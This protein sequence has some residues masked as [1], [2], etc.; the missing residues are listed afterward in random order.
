MRFT[1]IIYGTI[2]LPDWLIPFLK[3]PEFV[4]LRGIRLSNVDSFEFKDF[5]GPTRWEHCIGVAYLAMRCAKVKKLSES[6]R[7]HLILAALLHD[8]ATPPFAHTVEYVL[9][10]YDHEVESYRILSANDSMNSNPDF[11]IYASQLP[12]FRNLCA[13]TSKRDKVKIDPD[14]VA[15]MVV[16]DGELGFL[17]NGTIDL[18]NIDNVTRASLFLGIEINRTI[19]LAVTD[20]LAEFD[21]APINLE[22][23]TNVAVQ[24]WISYKN[25]MYEK[26]FMSSE[27]ELGRQ[28]FLQHIIRRAYKEGLPQKTIIWNTDEALLSVIEQ[29]GQKHIDVTNT[30]IFSESIPLKE[31]VQKYRLLESPNKYL[32]IAVDDIEKFKIIRNPLFSDW[33]ESELTTSTF[34]PFVLI[35]SK[36]FNTNNTLFNKEIGTIQIYKLGQME[37]KTGQAS[38]FIIDNIDTAEN[39]TKKTVEK[40]ISKHIQGA[41]KN[42][43]WL[44]LTRQRQDDIRAN[45][46]NV[47]NW[48]F[49]LSRNEGIHT[50]PATFVHAI[51]ATLITAL[52]LKGEMLLDPFGGT[53]QTAM[54]AVKLGCKVIS[55]DSNSLATL[56]ARVKLTYLTDNE[57][58][59][60]MS[61]SEDTILAGRKISTPNFEYIDKWHHPTTLDE[62]CQI[63]GFISSEQNEKLR[64][65]YTICFSDILTACTSR[66]GLQHGYF[67]DNTPL[68]K[69]VSKPEYVNAYKLFLLKV[70]RNITIIEKSYVYF[71]RNDLCPADEL[72]NAQVYQKDV[73]SISTNDL[74]ILDESVAGIITSPPYLCMADYTLGQ[75]LSYY[76]LFP[77]NF[78]TDFKNEIGSRRSRIGKEKALIDYL[79]KM[80]LFARNSNRMLKKDG[81][82]ATVI[83]APVANLYKA[84]NILSLLDNIFMDEGFELLWADFRPISWHRNHGYARLKNERISVYIKKS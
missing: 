51:P 66:H 79:H 14:V 53:G 65:F 33:L 84:E 26:F 39:L 41:L 18:D 72:S 35:N 15:S 4:R 69:G 43:P 37:L 63:K 29:F 77:E 30:N 25:R 13:V 78:N 8:V 74:D 22:R 46:D 47:G 50:Y 10:G 49:R 3:I 9:E 28:A 76:W 31:L 64:N 5:N 21:S 75:R 71:E 23:Q 61:V 62:L 40:A 68:K 45:L 56:V 83:G 60:A 2:E 24:E 32:E 16:G 27:E 42:R 58:A 36:R 82:M 12:Q 38:K 73:T 70:K 52:G 59:T 55:S 57:R 19:A 11:P 81:L 17:I 6:N 80:R 54:E 44:V 34:E 67:A 48:S 1:D 7:R 20:W